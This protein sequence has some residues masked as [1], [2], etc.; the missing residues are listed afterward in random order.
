MPNEK[1]NLNEELA[2]D[3]IAFTNIGIDDARSVIKY[4]RSEGIIDYDILKEYYD[5]SE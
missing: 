5:D 4:L 2:I 3:L 1:P